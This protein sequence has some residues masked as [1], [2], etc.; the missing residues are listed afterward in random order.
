[1]FDGFAERDALARLFNHGL[2]QRPIGDVGRFMMLI[3]ASGALAH[4]STME[5]LE[6]LVWT[7]DRELLHPE[8][9]GV[10]AET[11]C[12]MFAPEGMIQSRAAE[13]FAW[14]AKGRADDR[15]LR[16]VA[17]HP[18]VVVR[19][20][21]ADAFLYAHEDAE[22][23]RERVRG[24]AREKDRPA[25]GVPRLTRHCDRAAFHRAVEAATLAADRLPK[26]RGIPSRATRRETC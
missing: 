7:D 15:L 4:E 22:Q 24:I 6:K 26:E 23:A 19:L 8:D 16:M 20:T 18:S 10:Q 3:S 9:V 21:A 11:G 12:C 1:M 14:I 17:E 25:I 5:A 13:M 2:G